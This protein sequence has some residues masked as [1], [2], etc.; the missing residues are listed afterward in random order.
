MDLIR[1]IIQLTDCLFISCMTA[2]II[3]STPFKG[4]YFNLAFRT[5]TVAF[6]STQ[7]STMLYYEY[8]TYF[9]LKKS[10]PRNV[11]AFWFWGVL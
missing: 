11:L 3:R 8:R 9:G 7:A 6:G 1:H 5:N 2:G 10:V 4:N